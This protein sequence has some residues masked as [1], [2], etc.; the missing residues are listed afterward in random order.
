MFDL[1]GFFRFGGWFASC[2]T[3]VGL[4]VEVQEEKRDKEAVDDESDAVAFRIGAV[5][6][7]VGQRVN[8]D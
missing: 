1:F 7:I 3:A 2:W 5:G 8:H 4:F 6:E